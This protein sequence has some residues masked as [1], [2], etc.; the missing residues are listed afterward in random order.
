MWSEKKEAHG[1]V[2][3]RRSWGVRVGVGLGTGAGP[4]A[5]SSQSSFLCSQVLE[6]MHVLQKPWESLGWFP[7]TLCHCLSTPV[8]THLL[9]ALPTLL[10]E[11]AR[12]RNEPTECYQNFIIKI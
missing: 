6:L 5:L 4:Q 10:S 3:G 9:I 2:R 8:D 1:P 12:I 7:S 11:V